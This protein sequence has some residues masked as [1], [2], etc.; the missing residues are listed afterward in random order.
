MTEVLEIGMVMP[1]SHT[2]RN[3][4]CM[5]K[6][7]IYHKCWLVPYRTWISRSPCLQMSADTLL[8]KKVRRDFVQISRISNGSYHWWPG[9]CH[10][11][12]LTKYRGVNSRWPA[13]VSPFVLWDVLQHIRRGKRRPQWINKSE[14]G[15]R[16]I[17]II[18]CLTNQC[19]TYLF[20][21]KIFCT[22][23]PIVFFPMDIGAIWLLR[24]FH[25]TWRSP[26]TSFHKVVNSWMVC[27]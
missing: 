7:I 27:P 18:S 26:Q 19:K 1:L 3:H 21:G 17:I 4:I 15:C 14:D 8:T 10:S 16:V 23:D 12:W 25:Y 6:L 20:S 9:W 24:M 2:R 11:K 22:N 13:R 5:V